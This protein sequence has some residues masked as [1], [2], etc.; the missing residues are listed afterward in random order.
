LLQM[1]LQQ[2]RAIRSKD[3][4]RTGS[5]TLGLQKL[6]RQA[7]GQ[8]MRANVWRQAKTQLNVTTG[9]WGSVNVLYLLTIDV[10]SS[11]DVVRRCASRLLSA[12]LVLQFG[13]A[14]PAS[15]AL[16]LLVMMLSFISS[17][18]TLVVVDGLHEQQAPQTA[19]GF[20]LPGRG[21]RCHEVQAAWRVISRR[22]GGL[23]A[24]LVFTPRHCLPPA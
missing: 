4:W 12:K 6:T 9:V 10:S 3:V 1:T 7:S 5:R 16:L 21:R 22:L 17:G 18:R 8:R 11:G 20:K 19:P 13:E 24:R 23:R 14:S 2:I 15:E